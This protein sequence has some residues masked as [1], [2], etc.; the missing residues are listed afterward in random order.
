[1]NNSTKLYADISGLGNSTVLDN[2][3]MEYVWEN[4]I[5]NKINP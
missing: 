1:M 2:I 5:H 4:A 3:F